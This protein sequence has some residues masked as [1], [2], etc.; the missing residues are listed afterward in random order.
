MLNKSNAQQRARLRE[1]LQVLYW[2]KVGLFHSLQEIADHLGR[3]KSII[4]KWLQTYRLQGLAGL[5]KW[6]FHQCG[7]R[8]SLS[9]DVRAELEQRLQDPHGGFAS[10]GDV[11]NWLFETYEL[12][13]PYSTVHRIVR[14]ELKAKLKIPRPLPIQRDEAAVV[15][16]KK[17]CPK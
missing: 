17:N 11:K 6:N 10:Y 2:I 13:L 14:Y 5:L 15:E 4:F 16:F 12:D 9:G 8:S 1:R 3:S 7:R